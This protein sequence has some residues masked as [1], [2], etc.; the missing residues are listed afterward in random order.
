[1]LRIFTIWVLKWKHLE[2]KY[3]EIYLISPPS[4][5]QLTSV[6]TRAFVSHET[7]YMC[8]QFETKKNAVAYTVFSRTRIFALKKW[9]IRSMTNFAETGAYKIDAVKRS[10]VAM[11]RLQRNYGRRRGWKRVR[12]VVSTTGRFFSPLGIWSLLL[13]M[14]WWW[15]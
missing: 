4:H 6:V 5:S 9:R 13:F 15:Q 11:V 1:M 2:R 14:W 8:F 7:I 12:S 3:K 10:G